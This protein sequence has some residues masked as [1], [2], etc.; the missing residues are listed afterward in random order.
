MGRNRIQMFAM[1]IAGAGLLAPHAFAKD[2]KNAGD[3]VEC[4]DGTLSKGG[5]GACS[6]H[7]GV[8]S[9]V[10]TSTESPTTVPES[11]TVM[12]KDGTS[13]KKGQGACSHHGGVAGPMSPSGSS[14]SPKGPSDQGIGGSAGDGRSTP[15]PSGSSAPNPTTAPPT[16]GK[17]NGSGAA[18]RGTSPEPSTRAPAG[19]PAKAT[20]RCKD[21]TLSYSA[22]HEG[23]CSHHGGVDQWMDAQK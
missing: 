13:A 22:H 19:K 14:K 3:Q 21:G 4:K 12:C 7:G 8:A 5:R 17:S 18:A 16:A 1:L 9:R 2:A 11:S 20:A 15:A 10:N 6:K 23:A